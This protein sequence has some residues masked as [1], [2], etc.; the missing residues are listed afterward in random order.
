LRGS[1]GPP[2]LIAIIQLGNGGAVET[3][4]GRRE[5]ANGPRG[6]RLHFVVALADIEDGLQAGHLEDL[7][8]AVDV[9]QE[10]PAAVGL[11]ALVEFEQ[12]AQRL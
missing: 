1:S 6:V 9:P 10:E 4:D 12:L 5:L 11:D 2:D 7:Q 8:D 3:R